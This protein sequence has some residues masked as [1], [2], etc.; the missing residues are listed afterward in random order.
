MVTS[1]HRHHEPTLAA[2]H[3]EVPMDVTIGSTPAPTLEYTLVEEILRDRRRDRRWRIIRFCVLLATFLG[4]VALIVIAGKTDDGS[5]GA[6][7]LRGP[8]AAL[9][10]ME[11][12][13]A[14]SEGISARRF[15]SV[16]ADAFADTAATGVVL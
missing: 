14:P 2:H 4:L 13:I 11:G 16:L 6:G 3:P 5:G 15:N 10:R 12:T 7:P 9:V 8:Y 1:R